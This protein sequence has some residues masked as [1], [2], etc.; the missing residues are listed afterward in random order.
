MRVSQQIWP[1]PVVIVST[2]SN[3]M[4]ASFVM[5]V[6]FEPKILA[7][8]ISPKRYTYELIKKEGYFAINVCSVENF[9]VAILCG[10]RS[11]RNY[12]K[13]AEIETEVGKYT[14]LLK[15]PISLECKLIDVRNYGDHAIFVGEVINEVV[16]SNEF[17][18]LLHKSG[19]EFYTAKNLKV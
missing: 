1:R 15:T 18:P 16:R 3:A 14:T 17:T 12:D 8:A 13:L 4:T 11:G 10:S 2:R 19:D 5:P 9:K 6:S 7:V